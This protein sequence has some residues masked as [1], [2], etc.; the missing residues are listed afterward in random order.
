MRTSGRTTYRVMRRVSFV[1]MLLGL[2]LASLSPAANAA[3]ST[4][5]AYVTDFGAGVNDP[6][7]PPSGGSSIFNN[8]V[9]GVPLPNGGTYNG[10]TFTNV[11][12]TTID[13]SP[14]TALA[15]FDTVVM[16]M[17]CSIGSH[18]VALGAI[19]TFLANGGKVMIFDSD[20]C[21]PSEHGAS[22]WSGF[23]FPFTATSPGPV[24]EGGDYL[25]VVPSS[26]TTG[27]AVGPQPPDAV[28]DANVFTSPAGPWCAAITG[29][30]DIDGQPAGIVEAY[31]RTPGGGLAIYEGED[32]W[33]TWKG[34]ALGPADLAHLKQVFDLML[35]QPFNPDGLPAGLDCPIPA[36]G[37]LLKPPSQ[38]H[39][40][41]GTATVIATVT[42]N[43]GNPVTG[44]NVT[45]KVIS[46]PDAGLTGTGTSPTNA[47]GDASF[48]FVGASPGT[49]T[50]EASFVD[51]L[52]TTHVSNDVT[53]AW[54]ALIVASG[55]NIGAVEGAPF[56]GAV[57]GFTDADTASTAGEYTATIDW[58][59]TLSSAGVVSGPTGGPFIVSGS[60]TYLEEGSFTVTVKI[61]DIDF[62]ANS[63]TTRS[64]ATVADAPI[65]AICATPANSSTSFNGPVAHLTDA[66]P[67]GTV[68]DYTATIAWGDLTSSPGTVSGPVGG[69]FVVSGAHVYTTTGPFT[70]TVAV[71]DVGGSTTTTSCTVL[72]FAA[73][74]GGTF[75]IGDRNAALGVPV[76]FWGAQ[77]WKSNDLSGGAAP[78]AF[79][80]FADMPTGLPACGVAWS[81]RPGNSPPPPAGPL[82]AFMAVIV[83]SS[84]SKS[85]STISGN[86]VHEVIVQTNAGYAANPGHAGTGTVVTVS[87]FAVTKA[88][89]LLGWEPKR[90]WRTELKTRTTLNDETTALLVTAGRIQG[91]IMKF[92]GVLF[93]PVTPFTPDGA[94]DVE[95]LK[96]HIGSRLPFGPGGVFPACGT[97]EFHALSIDEVAHR[98]D[99]PP[100][101]L[102]PG[103]VPVV[104][105]A[106]GPLGHALAAARAAE[107]AGAD[108]LLVLP[109]YLVTGPTDGL[110]AYIEAV[111]DASGLP[112]IVYHR[113][114]AK[115]TAAS[116]VRLAANPK[117]IGFKDGLGDVGLA[118]EIVSAVRAT[119]REDFAFFN[120]LL[121]AELT[122]GAYR[123]LGI[124]LYSSA[125]FAMAPEIAKAY[126]DAYMSGDEDRRNAL[127]EGFYAPL[128][129]LRDQTPGFGVSLIK[130]G[131]RLGGLARRPGPAAAGGP[132][133]GS[134]GPAEGHPGQGLRA[135]RPLMSA[136]VA[137][138]VRTAPRH[139]R[140][141]HPTPDRP[142]AAQ[143][144]SGCAG[145]PRDRHGDPDGRRRR[146]ARFLLD[147]HHRPAG[148][149]SA[150]RLRHRALHHGPARQS[151]D[152]VG[153]VVEAAA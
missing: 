105:G 122:Q 5:V 82:P 19:N 87:A 128:V 111:A 15:G 70:I 55:K 41:G 72:I 63:A 31:A 18:P 22:N 150:A 145:K 43:V 36:S 10:A 1:G 68:S 99:A 119:G 101:R 45:F 20:A 83:S 26:L 131:L 100:S 94:V 61:T 123:G 77:W 136:P 107:E 96:E 50:L 74:G 52:G 127:L 109:P 84:I 117:V 34:T 54:E 118:Q 73:V 125:A 17:V 124:P 103:K 46:G 44:A 81:T 85:G 108:A 148:R 38:T 89:D 129:R 143:L 8:A 9:G 66:D 95:L 4:K 132:H 37:I 30:S 86:T 92:D 152:G 110:V 138:T 80:G 121:T 88:R 12:I 47:S 140:P 114:N 14:G 151:R 91:D 56:S 120:G 59:D 116:M 13:S 16:Y 113:G 79:K 65:A 130:A 71:A 102:W 6:V 33:F 149:Q 104:A 153:P 29:Q 32:F 139:H 39:L 64:I 21:A 7:F 141:V 126:Y 42:D 58:G 75:V 40:T 97:G 135:G 28:G 133:R 62:V 134:A 49:D 112:V 69:P 2:I 67:N 3:T 25:A 78:A 76:V 147:A 106:G 35:A 115:F 27:L 142:A 23:L 57:A 93:F 48:S 53:V 144:G 60:H 146:G 11:P 51:S 90:S 24:G 137:D 98:G